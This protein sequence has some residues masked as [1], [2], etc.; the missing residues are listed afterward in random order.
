MVSSCATLAIGEV[1]AN[2]DQESKRILTELHE[3]IE[4]IELKNKT[5]TA[6]SRLNNRLLR[7]IGSQ[8][9][10]QI[11]ELHLS[12]HEIN[13]KIDRSQST[14]STDLSEMSYNISQQNKSTEELGPKLDSGVQKI[15]SQLY[16]TEES[17][18]SI[19]KTLS[20][21]VE[22]KNQPTLKNIVIALV[23]GFLFF[24]V[25]TVLLAFTLFDIQDLK[26]AVM[27]TNERLQ[28]IIN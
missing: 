8:A 3:S 9:E 18:L 4:R 24:A 7:D 5:I 25:I 1:N 23:G 6:S 13:D 27:M 17:A 11:E 2:E 12:N 26:S 20:K 28:L 15:S 21:K 16:R 10:K 22:N 14:L 19:A